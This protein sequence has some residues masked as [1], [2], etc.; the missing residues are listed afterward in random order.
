[1][2]LLEQAISYATRSALDVTPGLLPRPTPCRDWDLD[3]L[4]RHAGE[5]LAVL[6]DG[7]LTGRISLIAAAPCGGGPADPV[8]A[9]RYRA[10]RLIAARATTGRPRQALDIGDIPLAALTLECAGAIEIAVHGWDISQ[11]CGEGRPIP[12]AL[13]ASLLEI[14]P[15]L[16]PEHGR[17]P[18]FGPA[19]NLPG[20]AGAGD[21]LVAF[22]GRTPQPRRQPAA[23]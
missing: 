1:M 5:S 11:A 16:V 3:M 19:V 8:E 7:T 23:P 14:A 15:L 10:G 22:L 13:A 20:D 21:R 2:R 6:S 12:D 17:H 4:L 9:F 18:L